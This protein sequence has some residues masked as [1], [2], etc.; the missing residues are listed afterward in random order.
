[1]N[2]RPTPL[3]HLHFAKKEFRKSCRHYVRLKRGTGCSVLFLALA[4]PTAAVIQ[5]I[6]T[7][8]GSLVAVRAISTPWPVVIGQ[9]ICSL[10]MALYSRWKLKKRTKISWWSTI[11]WALLFLQAV[12]AI[13][14]TIHAA[15]VSVEERDTFPSVDYLDLPSSGV[16]VIAANAHAAARIRLTAD[17]SRDIHSICAFVT[18]IIALCLE[19][20]YFVGLIFLT[21][22]SVI[23]AQTTVAGSRVFPPPSVEIL[24][25]DCF[26][27]TYSSCVLDA[28]PTPGDFSAFVE[29]CI[30]AVTLFGVLGFNSAVWNS[31]RW[32]WHTEAKKIKAFRNMAI[33]GAIIG[34][35]PAL[36]TA[37]LRSQSVTVSGAPCRGAA[38]FNCSASGVFTMPG[39]PSGFWDLWA[40]G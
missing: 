9:I 8:D 32:V 21:D 14:F 30:G 22:I 7:P 27:L 34:G 24:S 15:V 2:S 6:I 39:S 31:P 4:Q 11:L 13:A 17:G 33:V 35:A 40:S 10:A 25:E 26:N 36:T 12:G 5:S 18:E 28:Q 38:G 3:P 20:S 19:I 37:M 16:V 1:M 23:S 29:Y